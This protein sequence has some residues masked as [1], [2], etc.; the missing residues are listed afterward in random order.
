[1]GLKSLSIGNLGTGH[2]TRMKQE[3]QLLGEDVDVVFKLPSGE[4]KKHKA[5]MGNYVEQL[6]VLLERTYE[7]PFS[8][9]EL[10]FNDKIMPDTLTLNDIK[11]FSPKQENIVVVKVSFFINEKLIFSRK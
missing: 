5:K 10:Y 7:L 4:A 1:K 6:K 3:E 8:E 9:Q 2:E 11:G